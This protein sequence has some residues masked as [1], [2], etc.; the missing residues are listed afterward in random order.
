MGEVHGCGVKRHR[1]WQVKHSD[2]LNF[3]AKQ[4]SYDHWH[5]IVKRN[6]SGAAVT[7]GDATGCLVLAER[8]GSMNLNERQ[9]PPA[10]ST[11]RCNRF[12]EH[13]SGRLEA[14]R[15]ARSLIQL[16]RDRIELML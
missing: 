9:Q 2:L 15:L 14:E 6:E 7:R 10:D 5:Y 1:V 3:F 16:S 4:A 12:A 8:G 13:L 11:G